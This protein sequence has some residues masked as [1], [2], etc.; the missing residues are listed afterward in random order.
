[1]SGTG[2]TPPTVASGI[3][4]LIGEAKTQT[5]LHDFG[6]DTW[7]EGLKVLVGSAVSEATLS[8]MGEMGFRRAVV[9]ALTNRLKVEDWHRRHPEIDEQTVE[10]EFM[11]VGLPRTGSTALSHMLGEDPAFRSL[12]TWEEGDPC[13]PPGADPA[14]D[15]TRIDATAMVLEMAHDHMAARLRSMLPQSADGPMEDHNLMAMEFKAQFFTVMG[16][17][18]SY[19][20]W[21]VHC[22]MEPAYHYAKRVLKLLQWKTDAK[23]WRLKCPT[24]TLF[25][26]AYVKV[27]PGVRFW[28]THRDVSK[29]LPSVCDLY[30][31]LLEDANPGIDPLYIGELNMG[32]WSIAM[33]RLLA[34]RRDPANDAR[35]F[36]I[37]FIEFQA[38]PISQIRRLY[39]WLGDELTPATVKRMR[40][41]RAGNPKDKHGTHTY[42]ADQFGISDQALTQRFGAY[43]DRFAPLLA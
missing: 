5:G 42:N 11:G 36:D 10:I 23:V 7:R 39:G 24:H 15:Q 2:G 25:L 20:D 18:P 38:D 32:H 16:R 28:Q 33:D 30:L 26:D 17:I 6:G 8:D 41:W 13:P 31:T 9:R 12:R 4:D 19:A 43:R 21:F 1:M 37:G 35:F 34:F 27:F 29:V 22:D 3:D 14:A 40:A